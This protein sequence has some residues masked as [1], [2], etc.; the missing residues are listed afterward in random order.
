M[1][2]YF[3]VRNESGHIQIDDTFFNYAFHSKGT[4]T[5]SVTVLDTSYAT[6]TLTGLT[7]YPIVAV[8]HAAGAYAYVRSFSGDTA[9]IAVS[10]KGA[11]GQVVSYY[12]FTPPNPGVASQ[13]FE[14]RNAAGQIVFHAGHR[15][16][17]VAGQFEGVPS[18]NGTDTNSTTLS[19]GKTYAVATLNR[20]AANRNVNQSPI[21]GDV[22]WWSYNFWGYWK[23]AANVVTMTSANFQ[24]YHADNTMP[25]AVSIPGRC[26]MLD[27]SGY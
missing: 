9:E 4:V 19:A 2:S 23:V 7:G 15:Y 8:S 3:L 24:A 17:R 25:A 27:V 18:T 20:A 14:V 13:G 1:S 16:M 26:L 6:I 12:V 5:T 11:A 10:A 21:P 22:D